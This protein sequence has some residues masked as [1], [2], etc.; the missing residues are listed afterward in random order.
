M[1]EVAD[2]FQI[3]LTRVEYVTERL[4]C[5]ALEE[6]FGDDPRTPIAEELARELRT[7]VM[8]GLEKLRGEAEDAPV[9]EFPQE[10]RR[11]QG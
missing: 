2:A 5:Q 8:Q 6:M 7:E 3:P 11:S 9:I 1:R 10:A 4:Q